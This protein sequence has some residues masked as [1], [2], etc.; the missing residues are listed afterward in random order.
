MLIT[1]FGS[2]IRVA[3][4]TAALAAMTAMTVAQL[5]NNRFIVGLGASG[6]QVVEGWH[7]VPYGSALE[8]TREYVQIIR[9]ILKRDAP[10]EHHGAHY[11]I[12]LRGGTGLGKPLNGEWVH[13]PDRFAAL[14]GLEPGELVSAEALSKVLLHPQGG[15]KGIPGGARRVL[16]LNQADTE[17]LREEGRQIA[18][19]CLEESLTLDPSHEGRG[20]GDGEL[21]IPAYHCAIVASLNHLSSESSK[22]RPVSS[23]HEPI[24]IVLLAAAA[25]LL[26]NHRYPLST[27]VPVL[28]RATLERAGF[29]VPKWIYH[30]EYW[31]H[32]SSIE[33]AFESIN[34]G[35]RTLDHNVPVHTTPVERAKKLTGI[36]PKMSAQIKVLLDEHQTSLYTSRIGD[37]TQ[38]RRAAFDIRQQVIIER[39]RRLFFGKRL[40]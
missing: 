3:P 7:G 34:F 23:V 32:L 21:F 18:E 15:L 30:W 9:T 29:E 14:A 31:G 38:A 37:V 20:E 10:L 24:A 22:A 1:D 19:K 25:T 35:L 27:H 39:I 26:I 2:G 12:P 11:D 16:L 8:R 5:S 13:R 4:P 40:P 6:P 28:V 36:L 17:A 33:K